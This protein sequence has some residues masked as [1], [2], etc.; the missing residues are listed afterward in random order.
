MEDGE[1]HIS[2]IKG[3]ALKDDKEGWITPTGNAGT[4]FT[5]ESKKYYSV[6]KSAPLDKLVAEGGE[7]LRELAEGEVVEIITGPTEA[8][9]KAIHRLRCRVLGDCAEGW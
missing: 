3:R 6:V 7:I 9:T 5:K 2:R 1:T 4:S 8:K